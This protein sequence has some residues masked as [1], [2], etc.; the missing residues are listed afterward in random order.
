M[1]HAIRGLYFAAAA[2]TALMVGACA[3]TD[4]RP[5][6]PAMSDP[7]RAGLVIEISLKPPLSVFGNA[8]LDT[9][10]FAKIDNADGPLQ[11]H[12]IPSSFIRNGRAYLLNVE[13]GTYV[14]VAGSYQAEKSPLLFSPNNL[15][16]P[17]LY[18]TYFSAQLVNAT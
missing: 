6:V 3:V 10:Y 1:N 17:S 4:S 18:I 7:D 8:P 5:T 16:S 11:E 9:V 12:V 2:S 13:P 14:A 15:F